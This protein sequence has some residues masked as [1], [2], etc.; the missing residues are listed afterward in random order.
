MTGS[1]V[2]QLILKDWRLQ[3]PLIFLTM[4][5]GVIALGVCQWGS[6]PTMVVG[7]VFFFIALI[8][9]GTML[10]IASIV[11]ERKKQNLAFLMSLPVS[12]TQYTTAK[13][14]STLGMFLIPWLMLLAAA[15]SLIRTRAFLPGGTI[16]LLVIL[17]FLPFVGFS[18]MMAAALIGEKEGWA[19]A[20]N[21]ACSSSYGLTWYFLG[22]NPALMV[23]TKAATPVWNSATLTVL[24]SEFALVVVILGLTYYLQ[25]K[26]RDFI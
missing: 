7:S 5:G 10:P 2:G 6:E 8:M 24:G 14:I 12:S 9:A 4:A 21:V 1:V 18:I 17:A 16:P 15:V 20:A 26:K 19:I 23:N 3:R 22:R 11:N 13:L 25:S